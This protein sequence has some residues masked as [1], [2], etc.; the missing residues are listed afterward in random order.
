[1]KVSFGSPLIPKA[2]SEKERREAL[3]DLIL[4]LFPLLKALPSRLI[5]PFLPHYTTTMPSATAMH[6]TAAERKRKRSFPL[7]P[8]QTT[9]PPNDCALTKL[10]LRNQRG[11][12]S[13]Q[14]LE[15]TSAGMSM[16]SQSGRE[17]D[18]GGNFVN[19][20]RW[21][22]GVGRSV[23]PLGLN[24]FAQEGRGEGARGGEALT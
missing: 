8:T 10:P 3:A 18:G 5:V 7:P 12:L 2:A 13:L 16:G 14:I 15:T 6:T 9:P 21:G 11:G 24:D 20:L 4:F 1:M 22:E 17:G 19:N 23:G